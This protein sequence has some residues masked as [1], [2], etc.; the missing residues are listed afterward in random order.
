AVS[1]KD[2]DIW[3]QMAMGFMYSHG[4]GVPK[5]DSK[6]FPWFLKAAQQGLPDAQYIVGYMYRNGE[7]VLQDYSEALVWL[8]K[9]ANHNVPDAQHEIGSM[10]LQGQGVPKSYMK[11]KEW[12]V[13]GARFGCEA[14]KARLSEVQQLID[15]ARRSISSRLKFW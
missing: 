3:S 10:Y 8:L 4:L 2:V 1:R 9:S 12:F 13:K 5:S 6:A 7:G 11:A 14:A 15:K